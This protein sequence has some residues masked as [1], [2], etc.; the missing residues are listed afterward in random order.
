[1]A[2]RQSSPAEESQARTAARRSRAA[3]SS[4]AA[5]ASRSRVAATAT[6]EVG[7]SMARTLG[8]SGADRPGRPGRLWTVAACGRPPSTERS[9]HDRCPTT[10]ARPVR[11]AGRA[12]GPRG[13]MQGVTSTA[14]QPDQP[15]RVDL[16]DVTP[17]IALG[18]LDGRYRGAVAPLVDHLSEAALN[19]ARIHVE[20][21]W[22]ITLCNGT[23]GDGTTEAPGA[24]VPGAPTLTDAEIAYL[25]RIPA[26]FGA[27]EIAEL[28]EIE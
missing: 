26:T 22:L 9:H 4:S 1:I 16:A 25:R 28:A 3:E 21:E 14:P 23:A 12:A 24:V 13:R 11:P 27:D 17:P 15:T 5:W 18:P 6:S 2:A 8:R 20:V 10:A 7:M 19:R